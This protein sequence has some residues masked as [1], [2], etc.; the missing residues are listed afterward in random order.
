MCKENSVKKRIHTLLIRK[1]QY[2]ISKINIQTKT[3]QLYVNSIKLDLRIGKF[4]F[5]LRP[6]ELF[7]L[8]FDFSMMI[9]IFRQL[10]LLVFADEF[11]LF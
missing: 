5:F 6:L 3:L 2:F 1:I 7:S 4:Y 9:L 11:E 8:Y 10:V